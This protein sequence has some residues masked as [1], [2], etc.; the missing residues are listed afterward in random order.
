MALA[1][2]SYLSPVRQVIGPIHHAAGRFRCSTLT[3][4]I[5]NLLLGQRECIPNSIQLFSSLYRFSPF[6]TAAMIP[7]AATAQT[8]AA[9]SPFYGHLAATATPLN[10]AG[11]TPLHL[12]QSTL[13]AANGIPVSSPSMQQPHPTL[14]QVPQ[15]QTAG[16]QAGTAG[17]PASA[18]PAG[19]WPYM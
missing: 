9:T 18:A 4:A 1:A 19:W 13:T 15:V 16:M 2:A 8:A 5:T 12:P 3:I 6:D 7:A 17:A 10:A 11:L 14:Q